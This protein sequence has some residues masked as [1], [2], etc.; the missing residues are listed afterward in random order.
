VEEVQGRGA[1]Y[2]AGKGGERT[3]DGGQWSE[4]K[5]SVIRRQGGENEE[6]KVEIRR[7]QKLIRNTPLFYFIYV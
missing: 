5:M 2:R 7:I 4:L 3:G 6:E 1:F